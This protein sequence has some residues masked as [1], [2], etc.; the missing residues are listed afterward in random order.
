MKSQRFCSKHLESVKQS[1]EQ[2]DR[3]RAVCSGSYVPSLHPLV[4]QGFRPALLLPPPPALESTGQC[5]DSHQEANPFEILTASC[6]RGA[7]LSSQGCSVSP[8]L[9][10]TS[11]PGMCWHKWVREL[12]YVTS[13]LAG[14]PACRPV[15]GPEICLSLASLRPFFSAP[16]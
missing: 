10:K 5:L 4:F 6:R 14:H 7:L 3:A 1:G 2:K 13:S 8:L 15:S 12:E 16:L 9:M 11:S